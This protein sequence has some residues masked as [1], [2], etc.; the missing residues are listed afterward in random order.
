[1]RL[2]FQDRLWVVYIP[3]VHMVKFQFLHNSLGIIL[4]TQ[5]CLVLYSFY[6]N[7]LS[8]F[9]MWLIDSSLYPHKLHLLFCGALSILALIWLVLMALFCAAIRRDSVSLFLSYVHVFSSE[10]SLV[11]RLKTSI[12]LVFF[13]FLFP[14]YF[15]SIYPLVISIV[16]GDY[17]QS[18]FAL[19]YVVVEL[20]YRCVNAVFW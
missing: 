20:L 17:N 10:M 5:S 13:L 1:M 11:S 2:I 7:F 9:I 15:R 18:S 16:S 3:F 4:P 12:E 19:L 8:S 6:A 14:G